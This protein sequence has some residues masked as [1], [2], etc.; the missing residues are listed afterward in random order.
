L[1]SFWVECDN[2]LHMVKPI[3]N[4]L[5]VFDGKSP[6][7]LDAWLILKALQEYVQNLKKD[8][9]FLL[10]DIATKFER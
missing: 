10:D 1:E 4:T 2:Y 8:S 6:A 7:M 5:L 9:F 3:L